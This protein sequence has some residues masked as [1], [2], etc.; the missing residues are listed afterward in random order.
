MPVWVTNLTTEAAT[1][2]GVD[3]QDDYDYLN[4]FSRELQLRGRM[5]VTLSDYEIAAINTGE[6]GRAYAAT[7]GPRDVTVWLVAPDGNPVAAEV[8]SN[9]AA[10]YDTATLVNTTYTLADPNHAPINVNYQ[11]GCATRVRPRQARRVGQLRSRKPASPT[12]PGHRRDRPAR[13]E[14][15]RLGSTTRPSG[16]TR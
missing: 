9:L 15:P 5:I 7:T 10:I 14:A 16:S 11:S 1:E 3:A 2:G 4:Y 6:V 8:K 13:L 12:S